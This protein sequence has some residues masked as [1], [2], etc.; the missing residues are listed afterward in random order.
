MQHTIF[1]KIPK[2]TFFFLGIISTVVALDQ[3]FKYKIRHNG[4]FFV[5]NKG[6][7]FGIQF[8]DVVFWLIIALFFLGALFYCLF[9]YKR[10]CFPHL[11]ILI[12]TGI[13]LF[14]SGAL[15]NFIDR[16]LISCVLDY[17]SLF[18]PSPIFNIADVSIFFGSFFVIFSLFFKRRG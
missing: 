9:L 13:A 10:G 7:S 6:I 16:I 14:I 3:F 1:K 18:K 5:C 17:I 2:K 12:I 8:S 4:G 15:S 11:S